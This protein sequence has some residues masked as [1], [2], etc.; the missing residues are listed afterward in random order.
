MMEFEG[1]SHTADKPIQEV[2]GL[3]LIDDPVV[4]EQLKAQF[5][6]PSGHATVVQTVMRHFN[7][8]V[9]SV[10]M[11]VGHYPSSLRPSRTHGKLSQTLLGTS[12][13]QM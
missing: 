1:P 5:I 13:G 4:F 2:Q 10:R 8:D 6:S 9:Y 11:Y 12:T 7:P 3:W